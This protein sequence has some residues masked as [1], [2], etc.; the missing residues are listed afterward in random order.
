ML[1][2]GKVTEI[3]CFC[4]TELWRGPDMVALDD[5]VGFGQ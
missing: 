3:P 5:L 1:F 4:W 2:W